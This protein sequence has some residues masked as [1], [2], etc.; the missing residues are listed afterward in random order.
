MGIQP[1]ILVYDENGRQ[2]GR[3]FGSA[4]LA[5]WP[6]EVAPDVAISVGRGYGFVRRLDALV[7]FA[8]L[9]P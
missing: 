7:V 5:K 9:L 1:A 6:G 2:L 8:N 3:C 4:I